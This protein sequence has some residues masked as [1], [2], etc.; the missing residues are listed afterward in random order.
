MRS[1]MR[2][3]PS[4]SS[5]F[6]GRTRTSDIAAKFR[7]EPPDGAGLRGLR[8][9]RRADAKP[10]PGHGRD[11]GKDVARRREETN[12]GEADRERGDHREDGAD[13][14]RRTVD[15]P[16]PRDEPIVVR[17]GRRDDTREDGSE[18]KPD[19]DGHERGCRA[20]GEERPRERG[21]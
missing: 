11:D 15:R 12:A 7:G 1:S 8:R 6:I 9:P 18:W 4:M 5:S 10:Q 16:G 20:A 17:T 13:D 21:G 19:R 14:R 3:M 2:Q